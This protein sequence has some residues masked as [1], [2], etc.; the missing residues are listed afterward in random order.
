MKK[1][2]ITLCKDNFKII[3]TNKKIHI[4]KDIDTCYK[5]TYYLKKL[6]YKSIIYY[7][8][9]EKIVAYNFETEEKQSFIKDLGK[10]LYENDNYIDTYDKMLKI[11]SKIIKEVNLC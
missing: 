10:I 9:I 5:T 7:H 11:N 3:D 4:E 8:L 2:I 6:K 1:Y